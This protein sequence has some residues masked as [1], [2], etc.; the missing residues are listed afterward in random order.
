MSALVFNVV[1]VLRSVDS[2][3]FK[4]Y[5][6]RLRH[7]AK[8]VC[9]KVKKALRPSKGRVHCKDTSPHPQSRTIAVQTSFESLVQTLTHNGELDMSHHRSS[10]NTNQSNSYGMSR[11]VGASGEGE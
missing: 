6:Q 2:P 3:L 4:D 8:K 1:E 10:L 9:Q 5:R 11:P 7:K